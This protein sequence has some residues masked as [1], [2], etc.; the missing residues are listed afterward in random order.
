M[1]RRTVSRPVCFCV[2]HP[3]GAQKQIFVTVRQFQVCWC[4]ALSLT[5]GRVCLL[6]LQLALAIVVILES[7]SH[8]THD[9]ILLSQIPDSGNLEDMAPY[10]YPGG[11]GWP[12]YTPKHR[13]E[14]AVPFP[15]GPRYIA[16][17]TGTVQ[18]TPFQQFLYCCV[19]I[20]WRAHIFIDTLLS[21]GRLFC[22]H[23]SA[24]QVSFLSIKY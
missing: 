18:E 3:S 16:S 17:S 8:G 9:H 12:S 1:L 5:R 10:L 22:L 14:P 13:V 24:L 11:I 19:R 7:E 21:N 6:Q 2:K 15:D 4:E 23:C 20:L